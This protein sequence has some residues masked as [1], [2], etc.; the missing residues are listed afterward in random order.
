MPGTP[1]L[2]Q[3][4]AD[5][6]SLHRFSSRE[7]MIVEAIIG[8]LD[9]RDYLDASFDELRLILPAEHP[10]DDSEIE[11]VL[12]RIQEVKPAGIGARNLRECL[13]LQLQLL[14]PATPG[15]ATAIQVV[16]NYLFYLAER[17]TEPLLKTL[18]ISR[19][20]LAQIINLIQALDPES[21]QN[22]AP[23]SVTYVAPDVIAIEH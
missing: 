19:D 15:F 20:T 1:S 8:C 9:S 3:T 6:F 14:D 12:G 22:L 5:E 4:V 21:G 11:H 23:E 16:E 17:R 13:L 18:Q 7:R 10:F 2:Q